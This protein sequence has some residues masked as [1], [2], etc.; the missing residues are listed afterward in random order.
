MT[1]IKSLVLVAGLAMTGSAMATVW[2]ANI[3]PGSNQNSAGGN[4]S[5]ITATYNDATRQF[6]WTV[7][8]SDRTTNGYWLA[9]SPGPNPKGRAGELAIVYFDATNL[10]APRVSVYEYNGLNDNNSFQFRSVA[11]QGTPPAATTQAGVLLG[12]SSAGTIPGLT[13]TAQNIGANG[14]RL[15]LTLDASSIQAYNPA[16]GG[17][18]WTG[19]SFANQIGVWFHSV[20]GLSAT[21]NGNN[22][23]SFNGT[24][25]WFDSNNIT[26]VPTPAGALALGMGGLLAARRRRTA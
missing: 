5:S 15:T 10:A 21:Y 22:L 6:G 24:Q 18:P 26:T 14:R 11:G 19:L 20:T 16:G 7:D 17:A 1:A 4:I 2:T 25:G 9:V 3:N 8:Y 12:S 13:A 23:T